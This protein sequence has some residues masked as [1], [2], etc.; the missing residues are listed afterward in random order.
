MLLTPL[1]TFAPAVETSLSRSAA[2]LLKTH[3]QHLHTNQIKSWKQAD[4]T[5][6][7]HIIK[8]TYFIH[9]HHRE[10]KSRG[11]TPHQLSRLLRH[12]GVMNSHTC[13]FDPTHVYKIVMS[14]PSLSLFIF[15]IRFWASCNK[16]TEN[17]NSAKCAGRSLSPLPLKKPTT[18]SEVELFF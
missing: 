9:S 5:Q 18:H 14:S 6:S 7:Y 15:N 16:E 1:S 10:E 2:L 4:N 8:S 11:R 13:L 17:N 12:V 3:T